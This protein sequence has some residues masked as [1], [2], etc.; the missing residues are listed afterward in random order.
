MTIFV[1]SLSQRE[2]CFRSRY[3]DWAMGWRVRDLNL[4]RDYILFCLKR[5]Y[6]LWDLPSRLLNGYLGSVLMI[7]RPDRA[8]TIQP[9]C[10]AEVKNRCSCTSF[11]SVCLN[12]VDGDN[13]TVYLCVEELAFCRMFF[14]LMRAGL[15]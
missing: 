14:G 12:G 1:S 6:R 13:L 4:D 2:P 9:P 7:K 8:V 15:L 10:N 3:S 11:S 5:S